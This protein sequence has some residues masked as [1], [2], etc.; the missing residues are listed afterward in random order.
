MKQ[1]MT[2]TT[3]AFVQL[4]LRGVVAVIAILIVGMYVPTVLASP[5]DDIANLE[6]QI[7]TLQKEADRLHGQANN[8]QNAMNQLA[9][10]KNALQAQV[11]LS[12]AKHDK[13]VSDIAAN[14]KKMDEQQK[15][16]S[17]AISDLAAGGDTSP[18][19]VLA[20]SRNIGDYIDQQ[21]YQSTI[22]D[23][24]QT[25]IGQIRKIKI[26][27]NNQKKE[28]ETVLAEQRVQRDQLA[29]KESEQAQLLA[30]TRGEEASYQGLVNKLKEQKAAAEAALARSLNS[31]SYKVSPVGPISAG[32]V[33]GAIGS[34]G[35]SSGPHLHLEVRTSGGVTD[36]T[37]YIKSDPINMP[38]GY[39]SQP[40]GNRDPI[41]VS[42]SHPGT[43]YATSGGAPI[44]AIDNGYLYRGCSDEMLGTSNN[45]YGYVAIIEHANG[46]KSVYA[47]MSGGPG[48]CNFNTYY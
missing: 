14:E 25:S 47:H 15:V 12:Q 23:Q 41:Y 44:F 20:S 11:N 45:A 42:G 16:M 39:I 34:T 19:E 7:K 4:A 48:A 1:K 38:P 37:P 6:E 33:V 28:V 9:V 5:A 43:D 17:S 24:L 2:S 31:G 10:E 8:Y 18:I 46:T 30:V 27:L 13:L 3:P 36:P 32:G 40:F 29:E 21:E 22:R 26:D 35:L